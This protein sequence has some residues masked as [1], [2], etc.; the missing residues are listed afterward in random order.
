MQPEQPRQGDKVMPTKADVEAVAITE[1][2]QNIKLKVT[3]GTTTGLAHRL[4]VGAFLA[5]M[6]NIYYNI[7]NKCSRR[8]GCPG[9]C[10]G[11]S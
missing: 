3:G 10:P 6:L 5:G 11:P 4:E 1:A 9:W 2:L 8:S 7:I